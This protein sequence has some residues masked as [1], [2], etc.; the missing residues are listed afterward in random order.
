MKRASLSI[1]LGVFLTGLSAARAESW[2]PVTPQE[3]A[4]QQSPVDKNA[5]AEALF[6]DIRV[7]DEVENNQYPH[8]MMIHYVRMKIFTDA[9]KDKY[10]TVTLVYAGKMHISDV[11]GRTVWRS[12]ISLPTGQ[13]AIQIR[14]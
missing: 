3:L 12:A 11:S 9:G 14:L 8:T 4:L 6:W 2:R 7:F 10:G 13:P 1:A 5:D